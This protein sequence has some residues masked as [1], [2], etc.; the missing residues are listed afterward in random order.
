[1]FHHRLRDPSDWLP[2][3]LSFVIS[4]S[5][6]CAP[7]ILNYLF[8]PYI[9]DRLSVSISSK[10]LCSATLHPYLHLSDS[11]LTRL[12]H[13][14]LVVSELIQYT[15]GNSLCMSGVIPIITP[16]SPIHSPFLLTNV[17]ISL[18]H[19]IHSQLPELPPTSNKLFSCY[20]VGS[21]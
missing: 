16:P 17:Y 20:K 8:G 4:I 2:S 5:F 1:M 11:F 9:P 10:N 15:R 13:R 19:P 3:N 21:Q 7:L 14:F 18:T 12:S 6:F